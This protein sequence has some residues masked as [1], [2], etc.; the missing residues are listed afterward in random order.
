VLSTFSDDGRSPAI[1]ERIYGRGKVV[2]ITTTA[3]QDWNRWAAQQS[4][5]AFI[6]D[7]ARYL[8]AGSSQRK[9][10]TVGEPFELEFPEEAWAEE[11]ELRNPM[12]E[13][14]PKD[15][16][17]VER[18]GKRFYTLEHME[19]DQAGVYTVS[20]NRP[21]KPEEE[22]HFGVNVEPEEG[23]LKKIDKEDIKGFAPKTFNFKWQGYAQ[24][25]DTEGAADD[26]DGKR[27]HL[28]FYFLI[29]A[30]GLLAIETILAQ[31]FG[32]RR[33]DSDIGTEI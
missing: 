14:E 22:L 19:T 29:A 24:A 18:E 6:Q 26:T 7:C 16:R 15:L 10:L 11:V 2:L 20:L 21:G 12:D 4:F 13:T 25:E 5:I 27:P 30:L 33:K 23:N 3:D 8:A 31:R 28:W 17:K 9:T 32:A 1:V